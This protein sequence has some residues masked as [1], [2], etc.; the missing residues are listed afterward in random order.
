MLPVW[1]GEAVEAVGS[2]VSSVAGAAGVDD[3]AGAAE[4]ETGVK[5]ESALVVVRCPERPKERASKVGRGGRM[6]VGESS[7]G[8]SSGMVGMDESEGVYVMAEERGKM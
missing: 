6:A 1:L 7:V 5:S 8:A 3:E 2:L 4:M